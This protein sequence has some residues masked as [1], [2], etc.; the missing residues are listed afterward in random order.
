MWLLGKYKYLHRT[1]KV[2]VYIFNN[3]GMYLNEI[4]AFSSEC[5]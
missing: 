1:I 4:N 5:S 3:K 2:S